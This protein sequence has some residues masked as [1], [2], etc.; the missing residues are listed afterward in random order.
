MIRVTAAID[1]LKRNYTL[2]ENPG[3][4]HKGSIIITT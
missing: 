2:E 3:S 1:W 4:V